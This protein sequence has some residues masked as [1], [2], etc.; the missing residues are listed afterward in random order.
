MMRCVIQRVFEASVHVGEGIAGSIQGGLLIYL[1]VAPNDTDDIARKM[2]SKIVK[3]RL[4]EDEQ[5]K[6]NLS[7]LD[8]KLAALVVSQFTL[9][10]DCSQ[11][12]RPFY[13]NVAKPEVASRLCALFVSEF[14]K[15]APCETGVFGAHMRVRSENDGPVTIVLDS[16]KI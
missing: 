6:M 14:R 8:K 1:A 10:A 3:L 13:G 2:V 9:Y 16:E 15:Q 12:N 5:G 11:G 4:F 7:L